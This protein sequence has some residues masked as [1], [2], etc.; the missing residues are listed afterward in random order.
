[1]RWTP[2]LTCWSALAIHPDLVD[3]HWLLSRLRRPN[4]APRIARI[5][6][7][8]ARVVPGE[9]EAFLG[10]AL[11][12]ELHDARDYPR[13]WAALERTCRAKR[14][15]LGYNIADD[16][17]LFARLLHRWTAAEIAAARALTNAR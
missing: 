11:H 7:A 14:S 12:N 16:R 13:A 17:D 2:P 5:E 4:P 8:L 9:D 3:A 15:C 10:Y 6:S 1:M